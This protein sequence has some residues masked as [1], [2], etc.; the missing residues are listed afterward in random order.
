MADFIHISVVLRRALDGMR[1]GEV[2]KRDL[3][4]SLASRRNQ[5]TPILGGDAASPVPPV[6]SDALDVV[7]GTNIRMDRRKVG[8]HV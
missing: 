3:D 2:I 5:R 7:T 4:L 6:D 8:P 1:G